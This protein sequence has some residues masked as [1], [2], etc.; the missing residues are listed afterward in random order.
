MTNHTNRH[1]FLS[2]HSTVRSSIARPNHHQCDFWTVSATSALVVGWPEQNPA[3]FEKLPRAGIDRRLPG[4]M[5]TITAHP[6][7]R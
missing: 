3:V 7:A 1:R 4:T 6:P 5:P 2:S